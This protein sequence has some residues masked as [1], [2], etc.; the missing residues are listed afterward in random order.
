MMDA[1]YHTQGYDSHLFNFLPGTHIFPSVL[2][3][4]LLVIFAVSL[5][6]WTEIGACARRH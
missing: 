4:L 2:W 1:I 5:D 3:L 6:A